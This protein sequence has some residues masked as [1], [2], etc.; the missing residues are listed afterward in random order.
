MMFVFLCVLSHN[1]FSKAIDKKRLL[2]QFESYVFCFPP[3]TRGKIVGQ[4]HRVSP[5]ECFCLQKF[6][7]KKA[8]SEIITLYSSQSSPFC[9]WLSQVDNMSNHSTR[10]TTKMAVEKFMCTFQACL[11]K[12]LSFFPNKPH[13]IMCPAVLGIVVMNST[14]AFRFC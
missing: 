10:N 7:Q 14:S 2:S 1:L 13:F 4:E 11:L 3:Y 12:I 9:L 6:T 8:V 5:V